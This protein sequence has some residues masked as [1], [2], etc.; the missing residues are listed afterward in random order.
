MLHNDCFLYWSFSS[1]DLYNSEA[2][3][4]QIE[5]SDVDSCLE[6]PTGEQESMSC[7]EL[8]DVIL[9]SCRLSKET[10]ILLKLLGK[11]VNCVNKSQFPFA[12]KIL[13]TC[14]T[15]IRKRSMA[16]QVKPNKCQSGMFV[17]FLCSGC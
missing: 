15:R 7:N 4:P 6:W 16:H 11:L 12:V 2:M 5:G 13:A 14:S 8:S 9:D 1:A 10:S 17:L 3:Q